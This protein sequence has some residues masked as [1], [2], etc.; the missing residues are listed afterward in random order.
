MN[1]DAGRIKRKLLVLWAPV[2]TVV[3]AFAVTVQLLYTSILRTQPDQ[4]FWLRSTYYT[5]ISLVGLAAVFVFF[6]IFK[7]LE[8]YRLREALHREA[9]EL[10]AVRARF[11]ELSDLFQ[12]ASS[13]NLPFS[14]RVMLKILVRRAVG[15]LHAQQASVMLIDREKGTLETR[16][17]YGV[18]GEFAREGKLKLGEGVAGWVAEHQEA[19]LLNRGDEATN[20]LLGKHFKPHRKISSALC[21]PLLVKNQCVGVLNV[22]RIDHPESFGAK[23]LEILKLFAQHV[24]GVIQRTSFLEE[25]GSK[26]RSLE[27]ANAKLAEYNRMKDAFLS[28]ASHELKT[29]LTSVIAYAELLNANR[30]KLDAGQQSEFLQRLND[31]ATRL[32]GLIEDLL[33]LSRLETGKAKLNLQAVPLAEVVEAASGTVHA[34]AAGRGV[35]VEIA[36]AENVGEVRIDAVKIGQVLINL[37]V[38]AIRYSPEGEAVR[39]EA[40]RAGGAVVIRVLDRG[41]GVSVEDRSKIFALFNQGE[42]SAQLG[43]GVGIGLHLVK[44]IVELHGGEAGVE[45]R[46]GG[47]S[48]FWVRLGVEGAGSKRTAA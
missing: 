45:A 32:L 37:L 47:G 39:V 40:A 4:G 23:Q 30:A 18:E 13:L 12:V 33:D 46:P 7:Q 2:G 38:N 3:L 22:N 11:G 14:S 29:P 15:A 28:T 27:E 16:A 21:V 31:E 25:L 36:V 42:R 9:E 5:G 20:R 17:S 19:L 8:L 48:V 44:R 43:G 35:R 10:A 34:H 6:S 41:P 24:G 26:A 1:E